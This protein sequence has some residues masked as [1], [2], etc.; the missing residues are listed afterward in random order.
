MHPLRELRFLDTKNI[1]DA[2]TNAEV[3]Y[4][5]SGSLTSFKY[6]SI[7]EWSEHMTRIFNGSTGIIF[8]KNH[9]IL[10]DTELT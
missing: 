7:T 5:K 6:F 9:P 10:K 1:S 8:S 3:K 4:N 2:Y